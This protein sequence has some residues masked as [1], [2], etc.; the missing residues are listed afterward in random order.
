[1]R[2]SPTPHKELAAQEQ[3]S[4]TQDGCLPP[5]L[6][7]EAGTV[8]PAPLPLGTPSGAGPGQCR[9]PVDN[10]KWQSWLPAPAPLA[11][12]ATHLPMLVPPPRLPAVTA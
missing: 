6:S 7:N 4:L 11:S 8:P 1:M 10:G 9:I 12:I 2:E 3:K 5:C